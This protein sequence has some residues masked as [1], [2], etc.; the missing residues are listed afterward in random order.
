MTLREALEEYKS[1]YM[2]SRNLAERTRIEYVNDLLD[3]VNSLEE[4]GKQRVEDV[5]LRD[6]EWYLAQL[7][8]KGIAGSTR[9]RKTIS[10]RSLFSFLQGSGYVSY[11]VSQKLILPI[12]ESRIPRFLSQTEYKRL[13]ATCDQNARDTA[14][15]EVLLQTGIRLSELTHL[16][17]ADIELP[18]DISGVEKGIGLLRVVGK[19]LRSE[20]TI[21]LNHKVC[22]ALMAYFDVRTEGDWE[23]LFV[24]KWGKRL[25]SRGVQKLIQYYYQ[26]AGIERAKVNTLRHTFGIQH[27]IKGTSLKTIQEVMGHKD[28]RTTQ[29]YV[30]AAQEVMRKELQQHAL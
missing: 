11:N 17:L 25:G 9:K 7:D 30:V 19:H 23:A 28:S 26:K 29:L 6:L 10:I 13:L 5:S 27:V 2:P 12:V 8:R 22:K 1:I 20:R 21:P 4:V 3:L 24:N 14:I 16:R 18:D 15:I